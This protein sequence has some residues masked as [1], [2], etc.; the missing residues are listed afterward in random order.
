MHNVLF[1]NGQSA[2]VA[3]ALVSTAPPGF[4]VSVVSSKASEAEIV[5]AI[6]DAEFLVLHPAAV[7]ANAL[8]AASKLRLIQLL[9]AGYDQ[10]D[11]A[12]TKALGVPVATNGGANSWAVAEHTVALLLALYKRICD[13]DRSVREGTWR[14]P[15][16]GFN[17]YEVA[18][19]T[20]GLVGF[21]NI[22][23]K[24]ARRLH[25][26]ETRILY[27]DPIPAADIERDLGATRV[28]LSALLREADVV[29]LHLPLR[30]DTRGSI[31][32]AEF[33]SMKSTAVLL[34]TSR[35]EIVD[36]P[37]LLAAL[38]GGQIRGAGLDVFHQEP[39]PKD[40][41]LLRL[42]NVVLSPHTAGHALEG[43]GRRIEF[44]WENILRSVAGNAPASIATPD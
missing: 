24:V 16:T 34:N 22:G 41:P 11:L 32:A 37:A 38:T 35:A 29:S 14:K 1:I 3:S 7:S 40:H 42:P 25:A 12:L 9:T 18:G 13:C 20:V 44:A 39:I 19:K 28:L 33:A 2:E 5:D 36:E 15:I 43:W 10:I 21:G 26:F 23:R 31:G 8:R 27:F 4:A 6:A 17:T 30:H